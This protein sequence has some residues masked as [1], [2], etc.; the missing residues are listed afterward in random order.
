M[1]F[2]KIKN[3]KKLGIALDNSV[4]LVYKDSKMSIV[5]DVED[6]KGYKYIYINDNIEKEEM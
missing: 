6:A 3:A 2:D 1:F 4:A 5:K